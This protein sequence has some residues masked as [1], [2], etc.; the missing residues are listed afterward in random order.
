[1]LSRLSTSG[2]TPGQPV[3]NDAGATVDWA[4]WYRIVQAFRF[5]P[6]TT[7]TQR[8]YRD[9]IRPNPGRSR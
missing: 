4:L 7:E 2:G 8:S 1:M 9:R 5:Y 3:I 6:L